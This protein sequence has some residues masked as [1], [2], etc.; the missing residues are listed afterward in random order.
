MTAT[1][2]AAVIGS[3]ELSCGTKLK[4]SVRAVRT[5]NL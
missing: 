5:L 2:E 4:V 3:C 1:S